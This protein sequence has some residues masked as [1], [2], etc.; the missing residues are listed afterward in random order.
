MEPFGLALTVAGSVAALKGTLDTAFLIQSYFD[1]YESDCSGAA[2]NFHIENTRLRMWTELYEIDD[3]FK[4]IV[5]SREEIILR[6]LGKIKGLHSQAEELVDKH[7]LKLPS[8]PRGATEQGPQGNA[9]ITRTL[10]MLRARPKSKMSW[11][12]KSKAKFKEIVSDIRKYIDDLENL[13]NYPPSTMS[14]SSALPQRAL[15]QIDDPDLLRE[16]KRHETDRDLDLKLVLSAN[17]KL[18][19]GQ[20][21]SKTS[22]LAKRLRREDIEFL[23][24][25]RNTGLLQSAK[26]S[27]HP[28]CVWVEWHEFDST[29]SSNQHFDRI[30]SLGHFLNEASD[31]RLRLPPCYGVYEDMIHML[32][33]QTRRVGYVFGPPMVM[34]PPGNPLYE[35]NI[36]QHEPKTLSS[37]LSESK[38]GVYGPPLGDRFTLAFNLAAA[39]SLFH[40]AGW[41]HKGLHSAN[42]RFF[43]RS[44]NRGITI[45]EPFITGFQ[46][47]R[48]QN[49]ASLSND[50]LD[51][52]NLQYYYHP[53]ADKGFSKQ[54]DLYS[55]G[56][57][58]CEIADWQ[59]L[60]SK[61]NPKKRNE[62]TS[63]THWR[64][65]LV[66]FCRTKLGYMMGE[67]YQKA[68]TALLDSSLPGDGEGGANNEL[69]AQD[70]HSKV[71]HPLS[72][73]KA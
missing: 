20:L 11:T 2:L 14:L 43:N 10:S 71:L 28:T 19:Q 7:D 54:R 24:R 9:A 38:R 36:A 64:D 58:L 5:Q 41:L 42:I 67:N 18:L 26:A 22:Q 48:P 53:E 60:P 33:N 3:H 62:L 8:F 27:A 40:A 57:V 25:N 12:I 35:R 39:F 6:T 59:T 73:C 61:V 66:R 50:L 23:N 32:E 15:A 65:Y 55:L 4:N 63:R 30:M 29:S 37:L 45:T 16:L 1:K 49:E 69:F 56:V 17:A 13:S 47:S 44:D 72:I 68:V 51:N 46:Y 31:P 70:F 34:S 52:P 21:N